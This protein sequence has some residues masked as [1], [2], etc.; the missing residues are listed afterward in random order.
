MPHVTRALPWLKSH[1][2]A[3]RVDGP[4]RVDDHLSL[5]GLDRIDH[6]GDGARV[7]LL[8]GLVERAGQLARE[9][10]QDRA[11][12]TCCVFTSTLES[13]QPNPGCEWYHPT[14]ISGLSPKGTSAP[15]QRS[16]TQR[17]HRPVCLSMSI[18]LVWK[19]GSTASTDTPVPLCG[20]AKTSI[21]SPSARNRTGTGAATH[22]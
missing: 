9:V 17:A 5:D 8:K 3:L 20:I 15:P 1:H 6:D 22:R 4:E 18:I 10:E 2:N 13:Q 7:K 14:T 19:T 16:G 12:R 21:A 11:P